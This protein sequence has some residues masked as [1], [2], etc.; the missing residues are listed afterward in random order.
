MGVWL[1]GTLEKGRLDG[2]PKCV[3]GMA[4]QWRADQRE[5]GMDGVIRSAHFPF[6]FAFAAELLRLPDG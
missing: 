6:D 3:D 4:E 2:E 1:A 5:D